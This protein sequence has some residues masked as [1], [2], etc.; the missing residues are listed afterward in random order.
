[1]QKLKLPAIRLYELSTVIDNI[2]PKEL[3]DL[4]E[5]RL[6]TGI[7]KD[8]QDACKDY[9]EK[10]IALNLKINNVFK[11][12]QE[13]FAKELM[14]L[15]ATA[16]DVLAK[17]IDAEF[18]AETSKKFK[19]ETK[20]VSKSALEECEAELSDEKMAKLKEIFE[21]KGKDVYL[22]KDIL[23]KVADALGIE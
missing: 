3:A 4:K 14:S 23:L 18:Q 20:A 1:M 11:G 10:V 21:K 5:I 19:A 13:R 2:P 7:V 16:K 15:D 12:Y 6:A 8:L 9:S 22:K 17:E